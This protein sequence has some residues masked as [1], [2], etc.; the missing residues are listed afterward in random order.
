M[1]LSDIVFAAPGILF[2]FYFEDEP[3]RFVIIKLFCIGIT[4][5]L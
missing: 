1:S 5:S 2:V 3:L 4:I